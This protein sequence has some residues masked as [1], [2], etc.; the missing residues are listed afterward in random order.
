MRHDPGLAAIPPLRDILIVEGGR[1]L[2]FA[3]PVT[4][5]PFAQRWLVG[6]GQSAV[7]LRIQSRTRTLASLHQ[8]VAIPRGGALWASDR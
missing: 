4:D 2:L 7:R 1:T 3:C 8:S 5:D 6:R